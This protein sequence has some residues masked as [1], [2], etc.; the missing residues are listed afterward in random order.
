MKLSKF[1]VEYSK[2]EQKNIYLRELLSTASYRLD[3]LKD[4]KLLSKINKVLRE[5]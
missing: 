1:L 3:E 4:A 2:L 5:K